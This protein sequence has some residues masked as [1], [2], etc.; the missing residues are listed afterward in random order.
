MEAALEHLK[1]SKLGSST[2]ALDL[3]FSLERIMAKIWNMEVTETH[4]SKLLSVAAAP[5]RQGLTFSMY[6]EAKTIKTN[7][8]IKETG[9]KFLDNFY[10]QLERIGHAEGARRLNKR[11]VDWPSNNI[12]RMMR[13]RI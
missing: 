13:T 11:L 5:D 12:N 6:V 4:K 7:Q 1:T 2:N 3:P 10:R 8:K 9:A